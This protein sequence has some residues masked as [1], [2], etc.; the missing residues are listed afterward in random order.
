M[1]IFRQQKVGDWRIELEEIAEQEISNRIAQET[2]TLP[3]ALGLAMGGLA[4]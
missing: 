3:K 2:A 4:I 1:A